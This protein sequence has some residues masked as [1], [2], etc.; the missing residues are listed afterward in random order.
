MNCAVRAELSFS[1]F[2]VTRH[3]NNIHPVRAFAGVTSDKRDE[4]QDQERAPDEMASVEMGH[5][6]AV[7]SADASLVKPK[8][9]STPDRIGSLHLSRA[10]KEARRI[11]WP[12]IKKVRR[13]RDC[14]QRRQG[15][16]H[17]EI[18]RSL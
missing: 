18:A 17:V 2:G 11:C 4:G 1:H 12:L 10:E 3:A 6:V 15:L 8:F 9:D 16:P 5:H 14:E 13:V 7:I